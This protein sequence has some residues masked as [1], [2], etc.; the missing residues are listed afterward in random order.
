MSQWT[1]VSGIILLDYLTF[2]IG[3]P[4]EIKS[5]LSENIPTG[6][7]GPVEFRIHK[8]DDRWSDT[9]PRWGYIAIFGD[10]RDYYGS[11]ETIGKVK[12]WFYHVCQSLVSQKFIVRQAV[13]SIEVEFGGTWFIRFKDNKDSVMSK[14]IED[15]LVS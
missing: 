5:L 13:V 9:D 10:L 15:S 7:E 2:L 12:D 6:S 14:E 4:K 8:R 11:D 1:H 3:D